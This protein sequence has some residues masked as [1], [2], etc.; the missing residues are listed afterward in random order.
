MSRC[1]IESFDLPSYLFQLL[2]HSGMAMQ[3]GICEVIIG[4]PEKG[5]KVAEIGPG[6]FFGEVGADAHRACVVGLTP[7][8]SALLSDI[9]SVPCLP[10]PQP[11]GGADQAGVPISD[12]PLQDIR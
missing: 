8:P 3:H 9:I 6:G 4:D 5:K 12:Y 2:S 1:V 11:T 7:L 10:L